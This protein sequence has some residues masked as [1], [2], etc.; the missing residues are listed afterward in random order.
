MRRLNIRDVSSVSRR[1]AP[2]AILFSLQS[3]WFG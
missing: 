1:V 2:I 3:L